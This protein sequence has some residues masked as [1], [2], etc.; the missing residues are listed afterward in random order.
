MKK[1]IHIRGYVF[2][3]TLLNIALCANF[4]NCHCIYNFSSKVDILTL[5]LIINSFYIVEFIIAFIVPQHILLHKNT[6]I[7]LILYTS[8]INLINIYINSFHFVRLVRPELF[9]LN[10]KGVQNQ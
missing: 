8:I 2:L 1:Y 7:E 4:I 9:L 10:Y 5:C 3:I 6:F